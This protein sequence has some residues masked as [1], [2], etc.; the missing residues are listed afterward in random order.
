MVAYLKGQGAASDPIQARDAIGNCT[1]NGIDVVYLVA[2]LK[3]IG[4]PPV[5][6]DCET[7]IASRP[8]PLKGGR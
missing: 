4:A 5:R 8:K 7:V 1:T 2:Y 3:G 6:P